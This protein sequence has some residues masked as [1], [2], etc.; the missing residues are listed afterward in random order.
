VPPTP[1]ERLELAREIATEEGLQ[2][3]YIGNVP[4]HEANSTYCPICGATVVR[5]VGYTVDASGLSNGVCR[6]CGTVLPG[7]WD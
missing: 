1:V 5:R 6:A 3:V 4:G 2:Y 7:V